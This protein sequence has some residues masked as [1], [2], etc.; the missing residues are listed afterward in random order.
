M[1]SPESRNQL[2]PQLAMRVAL[3]GGIALAIFG[4]I[5]FRLWF[6]QVL[7]GDQY[8]AEASSNRVRNV[9][10]QAPRGELIDRNGT[11]LVENRNAVAVLVSP[12]AL[13]EDEGT[14]E[15][16]ITRLSRVLGRST[17]PERCELGRRR[18]M[19]MPVECAIDSQAAVT[20]YADAIVEPDA[21]RA[22]YSYLAE[23]ASE[24][25]GVSIENAWLRE[26]PLKSVGAHLFGTVGQIDEDGLRNPNY[27][28]VRGGSIVGKNGLEFTYDKY[29]RGT[30]GAQR[31]EV[32]AQGRP[33][34]RLTT[35]EPVKGSDVQLSIDARL[36]RVGQQALQTGIGLAQANGNPASGGAF[37]AMEPKTGEVLAM[38]SAPTFDP[39]DFTRPISQREYDRKYTAES[40]N[41]PLFNRAISGGFAIGSTFKIVTAAAA[42][43]DGQITETTPYNDT[44]SW[45]S[46]L[47]RRR[48]AGGAVFGTVT[49]ERALAVS[50][51]TYFYELGAKL[52]RDPARYPRGGALQDW[53]RKFGFGAQTG[54][55]VPN[56]YGGVVPDSRSADG[57]KAAERECRRVRRVDFCGK[58]YLEDTWTVGDN[59]SLAI[60]QGDFVGTP[61]QLATAYAALENGG[62]LVRPHIGVAAVGED[63]RLQQRFTVDPIRRFEIPGL[64]TIR[65]GL[66]DSTTQPDGTSTDVFEGFGKPV[67]GK[68]G[69]AQITNRP[70]QSWYV[71]YVPDERRPI[72]VAAVIEDG[73]F[74][75][76]AAA[77]AVRQIL[78]QW[79]YGNPG[80]VRAGGS[81]SY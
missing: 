34:G 24:F 22:A 52:N 3:L 74:G 68:T 58:A 59:V 23:R 21:S 14:R 32:D 27:R 79:F 65:Q 20:P 70:D 81:A 53:A 9:T 75:A 18:F 76:E 29:L 66:L 73:G 55:D 80:Q 43:A 39:N 71:A 25:P 6:L 40:A 77:P 62:T 26:Y 41:R 4:I 38:G 49:M 57:L 46:G 51:D 50:V 5:F 35:V 16:L 12:A 1:E 11:V 30:N 17:R 2:S 33:K 15:R 10:I 54:I 42:L 61:L 60:G 8:L 36:Q 67:Y 78:S 31:I 63:G 47:Q 37:V 48:N 13:P 45:V 69:T 28:G 56:E 44:G 64:A 72:V 7:S 19:R